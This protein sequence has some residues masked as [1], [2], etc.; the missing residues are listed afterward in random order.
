MC[1]IISI[2]L[3]VCVLS[4]LHFAVAQDSVAR[5]PIFSSRMD[6]NIH[7]L[8][9]SSF[10]A[11]SVGLA[12]GT[13]IAFVP[14]LKGI[15]PAVRDVVQTFRHNS[16]IED[17]FHG[18]DD[19]LQGVPATSV[20]I[21]KACGVPSK[22][23]YW[24][25]GMRMAMTYGLVLITTKSVKEWSAEPRPYNEW[26]Q[27]SFYSGHTCCAFAGA[28]MLR[29]EYK[30]VSPWIGI[31]A[32]AVCSFTGLLRV[33]NDRHWLGDVLAGAGAGILCAQVSYWICDNLQALGPRK[34]GIPISVQNTDPYKYSLVCYK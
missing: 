21:L 3:L 7:N 25:I 6:T 28:E 32:Y 26:I 9:V 4:M 18:V 27:N 23:N 22:H 17:F 13:A 31:G 15:N 30:D 11:P 34:D 8:G 2:L 5:C 10:I 1:R 29:L 12:A 24:D 33:Y 16:S 14:A 19:V 20:I